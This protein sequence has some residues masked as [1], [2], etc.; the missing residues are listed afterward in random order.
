MIQKPL[1]LNIVGFL[2]LA[3]PVS[4]TVLDL[5]HPPDYVRISL[6][7]RQGKLEEMRNE[8]GDELAS[9]WKPAQQGKGSSC[10]DE[11]F[12]RWVDLYQW[13]D[14]LESDESAV[15]KEWLSRHILVTDKKGGDN[16][17]SVQVTVLAP[18]SSPVRRDEEQNYHAIQ[19][20]AGNTKL[21]GQLLEK[22]VLQ[23]F[24]PQKGKLIDRLEPGF[25]TATINDPVFLNRWSSC[26]SSDDF[27]PRVLL[28]LQSIWKSNNGDWH[29]FLSLALSIAVVMDQPVPDYW[30]HHQVSQNDVP[31]VNLEPEVVFDNWVRSFRAG[32]LQRD[33]RFMDVMEL[34]FLVDAPLDPDEYEWVRSNSNQSRQTLRHV[35]ESIV[36][37]KGRVVKD[38]YL[39]PW[40]PYHL[41]DIRSHGG[42]CVDQ[43]YYAAICGKALGIPTVFFSGEGKDGG[44]AWIGYL[45][46]NRSW[47]LDVGRYKDQNYATG[48]ALNPQNWAPITDHDLEILTSHLGRKNHWYSAK[49]DLV[50]AQNFHRRGDSQN[51]G[52][53]LQSALMSCPEDPFFWDSRQNWM[54]QVGASPSEMKSH[55]EAA[56]R[57]FSRFRDLRAQHEEALAKIALVVGDMPTAEKLSD[58]IVRENRSGIGARSDLRASAANSLILAKINANDPDGALKEYERQIYIQGEDGGGDFLYKV[59]TPLTQYMNSHSRPDLARLVIKKAFDSLKPTKGSLVD[60]DLRKLWT[61]SGGLK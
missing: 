8:L 37:D 47:D 11:S 42:I 34:N 13:I 51:E 57:Q 29:N 35:F 7:E 22:L 40:G 5:S 25:V 20:L 27:A 53:A 14:L 6:L 15:T 58:Q 19:L 49:R 48:L 33:P 54:V 52:Q 39:W 26:F 61:E 1:T 43:A 4:A 56:I 36:Y 2:L 10:D 9:S 59:V 24:S 38:V 32:Q 44:H 12:S 55:H 41:S 28:N 45:K 18:G 21:I 50:M 17:G 60:R 30:P 31:K 3:S 46:G 23:P 16:N